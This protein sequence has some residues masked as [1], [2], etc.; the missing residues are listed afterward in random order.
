MRARAQ[1]ARYDGVQDPERDPR[2]S[3]EA[4]AIAEGEVEN[5]DEPPPC[6]K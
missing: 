2:L 5:E 4:W 6:L 3:V 1:H